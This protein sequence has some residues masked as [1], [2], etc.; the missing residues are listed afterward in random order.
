MMVA[1]LLKVVGRPSGVTGLA[2]AVL[3]ASLSTSALAQR[4]AIY[5]DDLASGRV[6]SVHQASRISSRFV[7]EGRPLTSQQPNQ[8]QPNQASTQQPQPRKSIFG[9]L[10]GLFKRSDQSQPVAQH[11]SAQSSRQQPSGVQQAAYAN[12]SSRGRTSSAQAQRP[13]QQAMPRSLRPTPQP[14]ATKS[15]SANSQRSAGGIAMRR[16][17]RRV[18]LF[19]LLSG[20]SKEEDTA[21]QM[22]AQ[23][24]QM[25]QQQKKLAQQRQMQQRQAQQKLAQQRQRLAQQSQAASQSIAENRPMPSGMPTPVTQ[26]IAEQPAWATDGVKT[27]SKPMRRTGI[28]SAARDPLALPNI[29]SSTSAP[30]PMAALAQM[31]PT[32]SQPSN[33][34]SVS[35]LE[36]DAAIFVSDNKLTASTGKPSDDVVFVTDD[37]EPT[38]AAT[39]KSIVV[40][41]E[42]TPFVAPVPS[43]LAPA[44][45]LAAAPMPKPLPM[46]SAP[47]AAGP[48]GMKPYPTAMP[49]SS[50]SKQMASSEPS[51][52][53]PNPVAAKPINNK[54]SDRAA[55]LLAEAHA[56][57]ASAVSEEDFT[58]LVQRCRMVLAIDRSQ[59]AIEYSNKLAS[60]ALN[61]RGE[62]RADTA[63]DQ[64]AMADFAEALELDKTRWRA[65]HNQGVLHAQ[66]GRYAEAFEAFNNTIRTNPKFAKA[67]SNRASLYV[68]SGNFQESLDD[69]WRAIQLDPDLAIAHKGRGRVCHMLG[70]MQESLQHYDAAVLLSS[71]DAH[72]AV[73]RADLLVDM[74]RYS[75]ALVGYEKAISLEPSMATAYRNLAWLQATCPVNDYRNPSAAL[76]NAEQ[77]IKL[78]GDEDDVSLD[79]LAAAQAAAGDY[80]AAAS[81]IERAMQLASE[82]DAVDYASRLALYQ[83][84]ESFVST[85][86]GE[87]R[88]ATYTK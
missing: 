25:Q 35:T 49:Q 69:Y 83:R 84:G 82:E 39:P 32:T 71:T 30:R 28:K 79:T 38:P 72:I 61:K 67:Y 9:G 78:S 68:Q 52:M 46:A 23:K 26:P 58:S 74:G 3:L 56:A 81:T 16:G 73:C 40:K 42:P 62:L 15:S 59:V 65:M 5:V 36:D 55:A 24:Q 87:V 4:D 18:G 14:A 60:W 41:A 88:Q 53:V 21:P 12:V 20:G 63:R 51:V 6:G 7:P 10:S 66:A 22:Q 29:K 31:Q 37:T 86:V 47:I 34:P 64:E 33:K 57:A 13:S 48:M 8:R 80:E 17:D 1:C 11:P 85:P 70:R 54:P 2:A 19:D 43:V 50:T 76:Q 45:E 75:Q 44:N 77:A 27:A